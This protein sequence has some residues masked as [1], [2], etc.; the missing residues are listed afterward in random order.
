MIGQTI[1]RR[2]HQDKQLLTNTFGPFFRIP[3]RKMLIYLQFDFKQ[4][5]REKDLTELL[6][7]NDDRAIK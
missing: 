6:H 5:L 4:N 3:N 7:F 1:G 2:N